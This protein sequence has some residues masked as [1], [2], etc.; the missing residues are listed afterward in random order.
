MSAVRARLLRVGPFVAL[1]LGAAQ[2][3]VWAGGLPPGAGTTGFAWRAALL[4]V[5]QVAA[6]AAVW[7]RRD[8]GTLWIVLALAVGFRAAAW[9]W[10]PELSSDLHRYVWDGRVQVSGRSPYDHPPAARELADLRDQ[11]IWP[12]INR[13]WAVTVYPPGAEMAFLALARAGIRSAEGVKAAALAVELGALALVTALVLR[14]RAPH[15]GLVLYAWSP[16]VI[17]ETAVSGHLDALVLPLVL[18]ALLLAEGRRFAWAGVL[19][20]AT[21]LL[22]LYPVLLLLAVPRGGRRVA[23][24]AAAATVAAG[25]LP[26]AA[27]SG[28]RVLGFL[29]DYFRRAEDFNVGWRGF[30][31]AALSF[32]G[33]WAR[34]LAMGLSAAALLGVALALVHRTDPDVFRLARALVFAFAMLAPMAK[35]PWYAL[36]LVPLLALDRSAAA[37]WLAAALP[38][39]YLKYGAPGGRMPAW[40]EPLE[41]LPPVGLAAIAWFRSRA[42]TAD[43]TP[44]GATPAGAAP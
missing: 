31:E 37:T 6:A 32:T 19:V 17:A 14:R 2:G 38:L 44:A 26:Y 22:K 20:G 40:V 33:P 15:G 5:M 34:P 9:T 39:S 11:R 16:L 25:Y 42:A 21:A 18:V 8:R 13:P 27:A 12:H 41:W 35:H 30:A 1:A 43:A 3:C 28:V 7:R 36:W 29:P 23:A 10:P 24:G 4:A